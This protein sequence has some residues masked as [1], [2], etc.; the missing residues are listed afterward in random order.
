LESAWL[1]KQLL[2]TIHTA[3]ESISEETSNVPSF[4]ICMPVKRERKFK[5]ISNKSVSTDFYSSEII[6]LL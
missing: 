1:A 6:W 5:N 4:K 2:L 3:S